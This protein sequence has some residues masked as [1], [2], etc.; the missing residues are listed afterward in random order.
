MDEDDF[1]GDPDF[2]RKLLDK[3]MYTRINLS[4]GEFE[5]LRWEPMITENGE[6][7]PESVMLFVDENQP[8]MMERE[9]AE[10]YIEAQN[11]IAIVNVGQQHKHKTVH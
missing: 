5:L 3:K 11:F 9:A 7:I 1:L 10:H 4:T 6:L 8:L 2:P